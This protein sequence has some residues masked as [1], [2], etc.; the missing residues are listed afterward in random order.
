MHEISRYS[1]AGNAPGGAAGMN[2]VVGVVSN[3]I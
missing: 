2:G 3:N 1:H